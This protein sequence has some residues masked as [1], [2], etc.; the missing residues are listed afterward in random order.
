MLNATWEVFEDGDDLVTA[1][2]KLGD[3]ACSRWAVGTVFVCWTSVW[4]ITI[5]WWC[6]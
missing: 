1:C 5:G 2:T 3:F 4:C 6:T